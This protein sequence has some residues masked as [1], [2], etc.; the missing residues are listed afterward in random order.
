MLVLDLDYIFKQ[1]EVIK[2]GIDVIYPGQTR[3][4]L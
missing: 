1:K 2:D 3:S 4:S